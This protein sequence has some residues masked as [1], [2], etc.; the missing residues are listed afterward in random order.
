MQEKENKLNES[1]QI[2]FKKNEAFA[3]VINDPH[4]LAQTAYNLKN[5][6]NSPEK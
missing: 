5:P 3:S 1:K 4:K 6:D 2:I